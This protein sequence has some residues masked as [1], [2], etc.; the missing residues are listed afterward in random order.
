M[1]QRLLLLSLVVG[2][3]SFSVGCGDNVQNSIVQPTVT[4]PR[5]TAPLDP[6]HARPPGSL[7]PL[8]N[9]RK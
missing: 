1:K 8:T 6:F 9:L 7:P 4:G 3:L 5:S 2:L